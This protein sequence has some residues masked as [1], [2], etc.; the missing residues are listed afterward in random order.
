MEQKKQFWTWF[1]GNEKELFE[2]SN[3]SPK[4]FRALKN[5]LEK[6]DKDLTYEISIIRADGKR[7]FAVSADGRINTFSVV[8]ETVKIAP[9]EN[10]PNWNIVAF[11]Q[12]TS[13]AGIIKFKNG[14]EV[15]VRKLKFNYT[16][17]AEQEQISLRIYCE[18]PIEYENYYD[19]GIPLLLDSLIGEYDAVTKIKHLNLLAINNPYDS[20][21][22]E[23]KDLVEVINNLKKS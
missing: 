15:D 10:L 19:I 22:Y 16:I 20:E 17:E 11:R 21:K 5:Q 14:F 4:I 8:I 2:S 13:N 1:L 6:I 23:M 12:K 3:N 7:E 9:I 18:S